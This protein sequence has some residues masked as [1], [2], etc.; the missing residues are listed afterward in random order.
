MI[1]KRLP[2][3]LLGKDL[4]DLSNEFC[5]SDEF[6]EPNI[7][8]SLLDELCELATRL[9]HRRD[10]SQWCTLTRGVDSLLDIAGEHMVPTFGLT[11]GNL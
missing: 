4:L 5:G 6:T 9:R 2:L 7:R 3:S 11:C 8:A 1:K 10:G